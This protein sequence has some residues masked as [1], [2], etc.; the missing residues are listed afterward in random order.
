[1][2]GVYVSKNKSK[3]ETCWALNSYYRY[4]SMAKMTGKQITRERALKELGTVVN[5]SQQPFGLFRDVESYTALIEK[6]F[7]PE[8][9]TFDLSLSG[10]STRFY[11][12]TKLAS[13][14]PSNKKCY[15]ALHAALRELL[16]DR[17]Y[18]PHIYTNQEVRLIGG[19][20]MSEFSSQL[21]IPLGMV[22]EGLGLEEARTA[23]QLA[24]FTHVP[25]GYYHLRTKNAT[26]P[27]A[28]EPLDADG[29]TVRDPRCLDMRKLKAALRRLPFEE[30]LDR[31]ARESEKSDDFHFRRD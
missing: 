14:S 23:R 17:G 29:M 2:R 13:L 5:R 30:A 21:Y 26:V 27:I 20:E 31:A 24:V 15:L 8:T 9:P 16:L 11:D 18:R 6:I 22:T 7:D 4:I 1:M 28:L 12:S 19:S 25:D 10:L 3:E